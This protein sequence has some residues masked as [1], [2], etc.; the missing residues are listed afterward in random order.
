MRFLQNPDDFHASFVSA[1]PFPHIV[2]DNL[3]PNEVL[4][5][6]LADFPEP[7]SDKW[8]NTITPRE[9]KLATKKPSEFSDAIRNFLYFLNSGEA[10]DF[11]EK[12][13]G[14]EH[15]VPDPHYWGGGLHQSVNGG[16]LKIHADFNWHN[17]IQLCRR[18]NLLT[19]L[20]KDW[21]D[22]Y[23]GKLELWDKDMK[24]CAD[25]ISPVFNRT[26]VFATT[27]FSYHGLPEPMVLPPGVSRK[28]I[29]IYYYTNG[30]PKAEI[31]PNHTTIYKRRGPEDWDDEATFKLDKFARKVLPPFI[32]DA[33]RFLTHKLRGY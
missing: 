20:N 7:D 18:L 27:D 16:F 1:K 24:V 9:K 2:I 17:R 6:V 22:E 3:F 13:T 5:Q 25:K 29:A 14:I 30:R 28:S 8:V 19:Y 4:E 12:L 11:L 21:K 23:G 32:V 31:S 15:L 33:K 10:I 26:V